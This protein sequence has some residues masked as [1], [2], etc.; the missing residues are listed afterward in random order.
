MIKSAKW[1]CLALFLAAGISGGCKKK[2]EKKEGEPTEKVVAGSGETKTPVPDSTKPV[3]IEDPTNDPK[4]VAAAKQL[5]TDCG[6]LLDQS[7][8]NTTKPNQKKSFYSCE[9]W[10]VFGDADFKGADATFVN[11]LDDKDV[12]VRAIG[13][14]GLGRLYDWQSNKD[15][16]TR[17]LAA[18]KNEKAPSPIDHNLAQRVGDIS[19]S[20]GFDEEI[21]KI[22]IDPNTSSDVKLSL[23]GWWHGPAAY[24]AVK[25]NASSTDPAVINAVVQG[26]VLHFEDHTEE[27]CAFWADHL[28][29]P[30]PTANEYALGHLTGGWGGNTT[31][32][33][34]SEDYITG[35][36]GG[37]SSSETKR[38]SADQLQK[39]VDVITKKFTA[40]ESDSSFGYALAFLA[41]DKLTPEP[42]KANVIAL[43]EQ[44]LA[45]KD[46]YLRSTALEAL[47]DSGDPKFMKL[48]QTFKDDEELKS[49]VERIN[50]E[51][52]EAKN[53]PK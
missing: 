39:A 7:T 26:Y 23:L 40:G 16:A 35:G 53:A 31:G 33:S 5:L 47:V 8:E 12:K 14:I 48:A 11:F 1:T 52:E 17:V 50:K 51:A 15:Q 2:E 27:A 37:P 24:E 45:K 44:M 6:A 30:D 21:K 13:V 49:T 9:K 29:T 10:A 20:L 43:L 4:V 34:E 46:H 19:Q 32:D 18:L 42:V 22:A 3:G 41:K 25:A 36:G 38:C 28:E